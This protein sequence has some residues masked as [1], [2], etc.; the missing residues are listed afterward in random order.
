MIFLAQARVNA[1]AAVV[2]DFEKRINDYVAIQKNAVKVVGTL[3]P[4]KESD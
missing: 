4:T 3:K 1:D 2:A